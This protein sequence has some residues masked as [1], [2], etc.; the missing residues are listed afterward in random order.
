MENRGDLEQTQMLC[1]ILFHIRIINV[2][3]DLW[4]KVVKENTTGSLLPYVGKST[5]VKG[6]QVGLNDLCLVS[7]DVLTRHFL[8]L[9]LYLF[10]KNSERAWETKV[11]LCK[12]VAVN[13][14]G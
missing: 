10:N 13:Y 12:E 7:G 5:Q 3:K 14:K 6:I 4:E 9:S 11:S 8:S 2:Q 1:S